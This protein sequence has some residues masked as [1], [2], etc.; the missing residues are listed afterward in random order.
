MTHICFSN[1]VSRSS[2]GAGGA[3]P[4]DDVNFTR[5]ILKLKHHDD[6]NYY[7]SKGKISKD[8]TEAE[9]IPIIVIFK[10]GKPI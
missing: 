4:L 10:N 2:A 7:L 6:H 1:L 5:I 8:H 3:G 9:K